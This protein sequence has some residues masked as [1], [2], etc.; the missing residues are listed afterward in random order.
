VVSKCGFQYTSEIPD[1]EATAGMVELPSWLR[2][3]EMRIQS[4]E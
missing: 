3:E 2:S 4:M 1:E